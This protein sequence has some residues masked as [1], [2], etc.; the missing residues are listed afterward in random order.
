MNPAKQFLFDR[1]FDPVCF[2]DP[3]SRGSQTAGH[4]K[5]ARRKRLLTIT[6]DDLA[7]VRTEGIDEGRAQAFAEASET[8][9][10]RT[11]QTLE[12]IADRLSELLRDRDEANAEAERDAVSVAI[13]IARKMVP[14]LHKRNALEE[15]ENTISSV[16]AQVLGVPEM[17]VWIPEDLGDVLGERL[18]SLSRA[19]GLSARLTLATDS[20][21]AGGDCRVEW[22]GGGAE[23]TATVTWSEIN[24][25]IDRNLGFVP[26]ITVNNADR[27]N[28]IEANS[29]ATLIQSDDEPSA[30]TDLEE[31]HD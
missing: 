8:A 5:Q 20:T 28:P 6:E 27:D 23:R 2:G 7:R 10:F 17:S 22:A 19:Q 31:S 15:I 21:L 29:D 26:A 13:A 16:M 3:G 4:H 11:A 24:A 25:V 12:A 9:E 14:E 1:S 18:G 30:Q